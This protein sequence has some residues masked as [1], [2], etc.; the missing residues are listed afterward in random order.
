MA[1]IHKATLS[2]T[3]LELIAEYLPTQPWFIQD[4]TPELVGAYR[5]DDPAGEVGLETHVVTAGERI[6]QVPL[7]YRGHELGG[8]EE[9]L[10]GTMDHSVLGKRWVYD[11][12]A[13]PIYVKAL[14]T[15]ILT[16]QQ[17]AELNVEGESQPRPSTVTVKG[18]GTLD[19]G[20]PALSASAPVSGSGV[21]IIDA[22]ELRL[23]VTRVLDVAA[24]A[25]ATTAAAPELHHELILKGQWAGLEKPVELASVIRN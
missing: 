11:A 13:D 14:A 21:T 16:G 12:C 2:P 9:W 8:A 10:I 24:D 4:G 22:G 20:V 17:Q 6:Y 18:S 19:G 23:K 15:A 25:S 5:F 3:K 1:I 7:S